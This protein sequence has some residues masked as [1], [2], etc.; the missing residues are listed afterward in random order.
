M[1]SILAGIL[2][3]IQYKAEV[4]IDLR[5]EFRPQ[6][7]AYC[8]RENPWRHGPYMRNPDRINRSC[9]SLN[10]IFIQRYYCPDCGKTMLEV[11]H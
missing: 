5:E 1:F 7:C 8:G 10:P 6:Q 3:L 4:E 9:D 2:S 11:T